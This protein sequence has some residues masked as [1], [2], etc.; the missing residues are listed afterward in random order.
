[1]TSGSGK[2][3]VIVDFQLVEI[4]AFSHIEIVP[5]IPFGTH[6][7]SHWRQVSVVDVSD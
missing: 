1:M 6:V 3:E 5:Q 4:K 2:F 7:E